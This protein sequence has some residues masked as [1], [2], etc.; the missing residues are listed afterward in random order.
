VLLSEN[1]ANLATLHR[2]HSLGVRICLD[3]FGVG[4]SSLSYLRS[5]PF[6]K[7]KI[8][9]SFVRDVV[10]KREAAA[11]VLA[12]TSLCKSLDMTVTAEGVETQDQM[13]Q[14]QRLG[15]D[16]AQ[17]YLI[18]SPWP[19]AGLEAFLTPAGAIEPHW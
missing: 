14:V 2:L 13:E 12:V 8:D 5:F 17:G 11:I 1:P 4:Y 19:G 9:R 7:V 15:C 3:D 6:K 16:E 18:G 10:A